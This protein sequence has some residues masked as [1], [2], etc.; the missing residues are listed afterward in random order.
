MQSLMELT[1]RDGVVRRLVERV[2]GAVAT[3][4]V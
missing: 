3:T 1:L 2:G 4:I